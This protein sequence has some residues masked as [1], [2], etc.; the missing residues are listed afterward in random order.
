MKHHRSKTEGLKYG[1]NLN[2]GTTKRLTSYYGRMPRQVLEAG[3][4]NSIQ[5]ARIFFTADP[6]NARAGKIKHDP[7]MRCPYTANMFLSEQIMMQALLLCT[8]KSV[9]L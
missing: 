3:Y 8:E 1:P 4:I 6:F 7:R 9:L 2:A 5:P